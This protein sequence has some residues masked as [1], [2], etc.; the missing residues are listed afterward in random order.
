MPARRFFVRDAHHAGE[1]VAIHGS[2]AHKI[3]N[4]LRLR[5]GDVIEVVDSAG[6][7]FSPQHS[8]RKMVRCTRAWAKRT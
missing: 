8:K 2:D 7:I 6:A 4:V 1:V 3:V 5:D